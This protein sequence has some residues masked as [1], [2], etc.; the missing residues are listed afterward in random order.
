MILRESVFRPFSL[1]SLLQADLFFP[2]INYYFI[3]INLAAGL[4]AFP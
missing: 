2:I 4:L 3:I 1:L